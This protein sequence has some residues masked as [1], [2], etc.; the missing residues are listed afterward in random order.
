MG[1]GLK[2]L[3]GQEG[4]RKHRHGSQERLISSFFSTLQKSNA[5]CNGLAIPFAIL[6]NFLKMF[7]FEMQLQT[8]NQMSNPARREG[9]IH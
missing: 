3:D 4:K 8:R 1:Q 2:I 6:L 9:Y 5:K 7:G